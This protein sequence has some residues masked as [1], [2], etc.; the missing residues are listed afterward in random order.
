M[1][2]MGRVRYRA[3]YAANKIENAMMM[4]RMMMMM[5]MTMMTMMMTLRL[6]CMGCEAML[7]AACGEILVALCRST[8]HCYDDDNDHDYDG[9]DQ[10]DI[11]SNDDGDNERQLVV[12]LENTPHSLISSVIT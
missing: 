10:E 5:T 2:Y 11:G 3:A 7:R 9:H 6:I 1:G 8:H 12:L 4:M